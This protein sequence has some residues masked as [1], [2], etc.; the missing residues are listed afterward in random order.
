MYYSFDLSLSYDRSTAPPKRVLPIEQ[1]S[2]FPSF[3][4][5]YPFLL[6]RS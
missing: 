2:V 3:N 1:S 5:R 4:F 6:S